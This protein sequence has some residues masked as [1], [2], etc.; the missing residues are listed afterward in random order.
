MEITKSFL[1]STLIHEYI[2]YNWEGKVFKKSKYIKD[3]NIEKKILI[4]CDSKFEILYFT[5]I[6]NQPSKIY[7]LLSGNFPKGS[8]K[9]L[10]RGN[11]GI[12][13]GKA[14]ELVSKSFFILSSII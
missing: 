8:S 6:L 2:D 13:F 4:K 9:T 14:F 7:L 10:S 5:A 11:I 12:D 1:E 3:P